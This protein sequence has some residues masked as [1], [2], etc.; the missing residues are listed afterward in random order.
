MARRAGSLALVLV[1]A[2]AGVT[3]AAAPS[4]AEIDVSDPTLIWTAGEDGS[5]TWDPDVVGGRV[6]VVRGDVDGATTQQLYVIDGVGQAEQL[7]ALTGEQYI[8][9]PRAFRDGVVFKVVGPRGS[10]DLW[11]SDGTAGGTRAVMTGFDTL[12]S[13]DVADD[14]IWFERSNDGE[15]WVTDAQGPTNTATRVTDLFAY[16]PPSPGSCLSPEQPGTWTSSPDVVGELGGALVVIA[17]ESRWSGCKPTVTGAGSELWSVDKRTLAVTQ[18]T[19]VPCQENAGSPRGCDARNQ[20][21]GGFVD[22]IAADGA[23]YARFVGWPSGGDTSRDDVWRVDADG[24][25]VVAT[26]IP[27]ALFGDGLALGSRAVFDGGVPE[28]WTIE[29]DGIWMA[30]AAGA[31]KVSGA[32]TDQNL[33]GVLDGEF[34]FLQDPARGSDALMAGDGSTVRTVADLNGARTADFTYATRGVTVGPRLVFPA[35]L[36][37]LSGVWTTGGGSASSRLWS[38]E[39]LPMELSTDGTL[40]AWAVGSMGYTTE[41]WASD[42]ALARAAS[43]TTLTGPDGLVHGRAATL[44]A[45]VS[46]PDGSSPRGEVTFRDGAAVLGSAPVV[47][48][49]A[50]FDL[51]RDLGVGRH[52]FRAD[53][54]GGPGLMPSASTVLPLDVRA[55]SQ[56]GLTLSRTRWPRSETSK[57]TI[58]VASMPDAPRLGKVAVMRGSEQVTKRALPGDGSGRTSFRLPRFPRGTWQVTARYLGSGEVAPSTSAAR[59]VTVTR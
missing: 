2:L 22:G 54:S 46:G 34:Y 4:G 35:W 53:Y 39:Y 55:E 42:P 37:D 13:Y 20:G 9:S 48:G 25:E 30:D 47:G 56:V 57:I 45:T 18:L 14:R 31:R 41:V 49:T 11:V 21:S 59:K 24:A 32:G 33:A 7:T 38:S 52:A 29:H 44:T 15:L 5:A 16:D 36:G 1:V 23:T 19:S 58:T 26:G 51:P 8:G 43:T 40:V 17:R 50:I 12:F 10:S 27:G 6:F 28:V 3:T